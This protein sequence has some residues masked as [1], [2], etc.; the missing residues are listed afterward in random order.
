MQL[1]ELEVERLT[2][3]EV[4]AER[5]VLSSVDANSLQVSQLTSTTGPL[6]FNIGS[7]VA[8]PSLPCFVQQQQN[9][10]GDGVAQQ[11]PSTELL[12]SGEAREAPSHHTLAAFSRPMQKESTGDKKDQ[13]PVMGTESEVS[14][15]LASSVPPVLPDASERRQA[16][17]E[18][19][20]P[21]I[22]EP[23]VGDLTLQLVS[24]SSRNMA[25]GACTFATSTYAMAQRVAE[26]G[27]QQLNEQLQRRGIF[28]D[29]KERENLKAVLLMLLLVVAAIF[30]L[31]LG[32]QRLSNH[33]D[34]YFPN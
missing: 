5:L 24:I 13:K 4:T 29:D 7:G 19:Q 26:L 18:S 14:H 20:A 16:A 8:M 12:P 11:S 28:F 33:W 17:V 9:V 22:A 21:D 10:N 1:S 32:K 30:L 23:S 2:V 3:R 34:F 15:V 25:R 6:L 31:G 27:L